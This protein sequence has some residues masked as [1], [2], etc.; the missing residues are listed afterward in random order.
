MAQPLPIPLPCPFCGS[1]PQ[2]WSKNGVDYI[3]CKDKGCSAHPK[4]GTTAGHVM[5]NRTGVCAVATRTTSGPS[6][7]YHRKKIQEIIQ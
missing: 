2:L 4:V 1:T 5:A 7:Y 3:G 6:L